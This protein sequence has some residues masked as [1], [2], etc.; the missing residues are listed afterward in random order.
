MQLSDWLKKSGNRMTQRALGEMVGVTQGR[1]SQIALKGTRDFPM[2]RKI[3][4]AT[5]HEVTADELLPASSRA[6]DAA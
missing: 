4:D 6:E 2:I 3:V 1:I 5:N